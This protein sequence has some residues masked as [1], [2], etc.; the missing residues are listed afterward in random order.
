VNYRTTDDDVRA[1]VTLAR[2]AGRTLAASV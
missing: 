1:L 2:D